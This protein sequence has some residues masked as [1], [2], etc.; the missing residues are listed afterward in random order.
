ME[1]GSFLCLGAIAK[2]KIEIKDI[3]VEQLRF[4]LKTFNRLGIEPT[5]SENSLVIDGSKELNIQTDISGRVATIYSAP[6]PGFNTD[7]MS[8]AIVAATQARGTLIFFEKMYEGRMFFTDS[9]MSM[10]ANIVLCDP[11][12][13]VVTG[14]QNLLAAHMSSPDVRAGM[15]LLSASLIA[16]GKSKIDNIYQIE[17][18]YSH[19][20]EKL[21]NLGAAITRLD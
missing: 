4:I 20:Y 19:I 9:L 12:R 15:A 14:P 3:D 5:I 2:G 16:K 7:L 21:V 18:G 8:V 11:H 17:R 1:I 10:G 13:I 6:W